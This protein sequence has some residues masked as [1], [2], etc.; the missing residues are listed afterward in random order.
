MQLANSSLILL[1]SL[2]F[3]GPRFAPGH[4]AWSACVQTHG[5][6]AGV[7]LF[8]W[9]NA[10]IERDRGNAGLLPGRIVQLPE[11]GHDIECQCGLSLRLG[12]SPW[13]LLGAATL[14]L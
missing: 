3:A 7:G 4:W 11:V 13:V 14:L 12:L 2:L 6:S 10:L 9:R 8:P 5:G 1:D